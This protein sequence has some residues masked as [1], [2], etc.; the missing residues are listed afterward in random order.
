[1][2]TVRDSTERYLEGR[3]KGRNVVILTS[4]INF[5]DQEVFPNVSLSDIISK[6]RM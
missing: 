5:T 1:M 4:D 2:K 3:P 6:V